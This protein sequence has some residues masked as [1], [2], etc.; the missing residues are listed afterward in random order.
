MFAGVA[1][2]A[3][4]DGADAALNGTATATG[5]GS[6]A[7]DFQHVDS[8]L[9]NDCDDNLHNLPLVTSQSGHVTLG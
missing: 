6:T 1:T 8:P 9:V 2:A 7:G 5:A 3:D 4:A